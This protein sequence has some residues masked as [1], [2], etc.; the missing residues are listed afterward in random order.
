MSDVKTG[1]KRAQRAKETRRRIREAA[2]SLFVERGYGATLLQDVADRAGVAGETIYFPFGN[3]RTL[4]KEVVD[5]TI[6][7]DDEPVATMDRPWFREALAATTAPAH[8]D[9]LVRGVR[10]LLERVAPIT[11]MLRAAAA[12]DPEVA[13][14]W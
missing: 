9:A 7:G 13:T 1:G 5:V 11:D 4:L 12:I 2:A 6:A 8:L 14:L 10:A 3:R